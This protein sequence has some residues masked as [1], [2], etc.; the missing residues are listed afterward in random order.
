MP[1]VPSASESKRQESRH[2]RPAELLST[3]GL[4][5]SIVDGGAVNYQVARVFTSV[6]SARCMR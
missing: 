4:Y 1:T 3:G 2:Q 6:R 5:Q